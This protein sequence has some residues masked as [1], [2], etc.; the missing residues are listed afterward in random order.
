MANKKVGRP[1]DSPKTIA[2]H[3]RID[4]QTNQILAEYCQQERITKSSGIVKG[5]QKLKDDI[6]K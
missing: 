3:C 6:K 5:I 4:E 1:T 2:I